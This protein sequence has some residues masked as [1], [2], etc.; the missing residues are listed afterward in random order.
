MLVLP[1]VVLKL[2][3]KGVTGDAFVA[4][5]VT[6]RCASDTGDEADISSLDR[7]PAAADMYRTGWMLFDPDSAGICPRTEAR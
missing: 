1:D 7:R 4:A 6:F 5:T 3:Q 2:A